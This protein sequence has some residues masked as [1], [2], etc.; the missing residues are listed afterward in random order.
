VLV[1]VAIHLLISELMH[2]IPSTNSLI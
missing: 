1:F 2:A